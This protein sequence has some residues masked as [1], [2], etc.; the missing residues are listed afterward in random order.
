MS[1]LKQWNW[2]GGG[3]G[4]WQLT[5]SQEELRSQLS[6]NFNY[7]EELAKLKSLSRK[8]EYLGV[9]VLLKALSGKEMCIGHYASGKPYIL[10]GEYQITISH[11]KGYIAVGIH[12]KWNIAMDIEYYGDR[13]KKVVSRFVRQDE[14][15]GREHLS[16][17]ML[18]YQYLLH[19]SAKETLFKLL[20]TNEVDFLKHLYICPFTASEEGVFEAEEYRTEM[21]NHYQIH[22]MLRDDFVCTWTVDAETAE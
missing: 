12:P 11:T 4:I 6:Q 2:Q 15:P 19:W 10:S 3:F 16:E 7:E 14:M 9:R 22:Y 17:R 18:I 20:D 1:L 8:M 13:V 5:E 21:N